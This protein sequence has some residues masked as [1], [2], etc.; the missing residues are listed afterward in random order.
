MA[1]QSPAVDVRLRSVHHSIVAVVQRKLVQ[2][3]LEGYLGDGLSPDDKPER[4]SD[5]D[6]D[7]RVTGY[8]PDDGWADDQFG[9]VWIDGSCVDE[10]RL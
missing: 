10:L 3:S 7:A 1:A 4:S 5:V 6:F 9:R 8:V 2:F